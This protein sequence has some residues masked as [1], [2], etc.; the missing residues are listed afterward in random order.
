MICLGGC[1]L[2]KPFNIY[3]FYPKVWYNKT[4]NSVTKVS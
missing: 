3:L 1:Q 2:K 4:F